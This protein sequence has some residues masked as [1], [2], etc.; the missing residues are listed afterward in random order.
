MDDFHLGYEYESHFLAYFFLS[1]S[2]LSINTTRLYIYFSL[3]F[4]CGT[5]RRFRGDLYDGGKSKHFDQVEINGYHTNPG[6]THNRLK[7][8]K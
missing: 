8:L 2:L 4:L 5:R 6:S 7:L 3:S 1:L